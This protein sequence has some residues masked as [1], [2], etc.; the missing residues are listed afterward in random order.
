MPLQP[1]RFCSCRPNCPNKIEKGQRFCKD[2][3]ARRD[4]ERPN[5][6]LRRLYFSERWRRLRAAQLEQEPACYDCKAKGKLEPAT[7]V[8]HK[9]K[10]R[11]ETEFFDALRLG[12]LCHRCHSIRTQRGE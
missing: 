12:S 2:G 10:P 6:G 8:H 7:D 4:A 9:Q 3:Q 11:N 5:A 1:L